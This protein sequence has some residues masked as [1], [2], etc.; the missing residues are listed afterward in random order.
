M[1]SKCLL[2]SNA[3]FV[4]AES[5]SASELLYKTIRESLFCV[6]FNLSIQI[7]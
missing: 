1:E 7:P 3:G 6:F 5:P 4:K 2:I